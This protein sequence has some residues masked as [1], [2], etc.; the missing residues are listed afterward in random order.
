MSFLSKLFGKSKGPDQA[1]RGLE[2]MQT[3]T[4]QE[5]IRSRMETEVLN[6]KAQRDAKAAE[7]DAAK[8]PTA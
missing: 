6:S 8:D 1:M 4:E 7:G 5:Q 2:P 3:A